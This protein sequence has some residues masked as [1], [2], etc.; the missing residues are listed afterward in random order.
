MPDKFFEQLKRYVE[1]CSPLDEHLFGETTDT[2]IVGKHLSSLL[3]AIGASKIISPHGLRHTHAS[4]L[5]GNGVD[6]QYVSARLGH[7]NVEITQTV[8][9]HLLDTKRE[10]ESDKTLDIL[11][12]K[13]QVSKSLKKVSKRCLDLK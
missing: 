7:S 3:I 6:I 1:E 13:Y 11:E 12:K 5:I 9:T 4:I 8:Y 2:K 10:L